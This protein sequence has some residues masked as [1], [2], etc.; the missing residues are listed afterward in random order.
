MN[1]VLKQNEMMQDKSWGAISLWDCVGCSKAN[2]NSLVYSCVVFAPIKTGWAQSVP[3]DLWIMFT[4]KQAKDMLLRKVANAWVNNINFIVR[5]LLGLLIFI[6]HFFHLCKY[7][8]S[9]NADVFS[10]KGS[11]RWSSGVALQQDACIFISGA[12]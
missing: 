10:C 7:E 1:D 2:S 6:P 5:P 12:R 8:L 9:I 11:V 4:T 3:N